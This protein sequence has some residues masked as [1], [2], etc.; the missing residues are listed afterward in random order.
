MHCDL[1][2]PWRRENFKFVFVFSVIGRLSSGNVSKCVESSCWGHVL[3]LIAFRE[4]EVDI[5]LIVFLFVPPPPTPKR[6]PQYIHKSHS[7]SF[8]LL[9]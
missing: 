2:E 8:T 6:Y 1:T 3:V 5:S 7:I 9:A 4:T